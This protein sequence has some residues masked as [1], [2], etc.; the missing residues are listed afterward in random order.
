MISESNTKVLVTGGAGFIG[1]ALVR[2]LVESQGHEVLNVDNLSYAGSIKSLDTIK[3]NDLYHF[4]QE[5]IC[6][7]KSIKSLIEN[8][9][10]NKI[11]HLAAESHVDRSISSPKDFL[12]TNVMGTYSMLQA[13]LQYFNNLKKE[14]EKK[15]KSFLFHHISTDEV[16]GELN[17]D[18]EKFSENT[19]Y[20]PSSPYSA[21]KASSDHLVMSWN[22]TFGLPT[23][24]TNCSNNYGP[25][26]FPE[27]LIPLTIVKAF[28]GN[29][30]PI[31]G[32]GKQIRDWLF[33]EDH[34]EALFQISTKCISGEKYNIGGNQE[35]TNISVVEAICS[36]L[37]VLCPPVNLKISSYK[38]LI[39]F[40]RDRPGHDFRYAIDMN[41]LFTDFKWEPKESFDTGLRKT[42]RWYLDNMDWVSDLIK[43]KVEIKNE[44]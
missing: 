34:V 15:S 39:T 2:Y 18:Q 30:I 16:Y 5:D 37:D 4:K 23:V 26:Q 27:K 36:E 35:K 6:N 44:K 28:N 25:F 33:V 24:I 17:L 7:E 40:V 21:S 38:E 42:I 19:P 1:S 11:M 3:H 29:P 9:R 10:P 13:S 12:E 20:D 43:D 31:Y 14:D 8:F 41:K 22:R 32:D